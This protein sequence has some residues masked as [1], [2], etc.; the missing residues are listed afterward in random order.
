MKPKIFAA[1]LARVLRRT[2]LA[3]THSLTLMPLASITAQA[4]ELRVMVHSSFS[5]PK[6][7]LAQFEAEAGVK[8]SVIKGGD[9]GEMHP[10]D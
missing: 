10:N 8:L 5:L 6:P 1:S 7:L 9:A 3:F 4:K 2:L